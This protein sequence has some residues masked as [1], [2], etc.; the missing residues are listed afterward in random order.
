MNYIWGIFAGLF[1]ALTGFV[2]K[3]I[4]P[5]NCCEEKDNFF[6][7]IYVLIM[8]VFVIILEYLRWKTF[9]KALQIMNTGL[10]TVVA[11]A[12]NILITVN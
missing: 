11:F 2:Y 7:V 1:A 5:N 6:K 9:I 8:I 12:S 3:N 10:A 4:N